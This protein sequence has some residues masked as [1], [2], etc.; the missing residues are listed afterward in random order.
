METAMDTDSRHSKHAANDASYV[1]PGATRE[2]A[3][4]NDPAHE[5]APPADRAP[6]VSLSRRRF[7]LSAT[8]APVATA[9]VGAL[10]MTSLCGTAGF[11][12]ALLGAA[13]EAHAAD[14]PA[15]TA[16][17]ITIDNFSFAPATLTV[18]AGTTVK[19]IN[20]DDIPH[21]VVSDASPRVFKSS[22]LDTDDAFSYTFTQPGT[23]KYFCSMHSH[24]TGTV[25]VT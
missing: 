6:C 17:T 24:M 2:S 14:A 25:I 5:I 1:T 21:T 16:N 9:V 8:L 20:H 3:A 7:T 19:W 13:R 11:A 23:F 15:P 22:P 4:H 10:G 12:T 18:A